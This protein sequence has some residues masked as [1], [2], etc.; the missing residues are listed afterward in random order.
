MIR[1]TSKGL[2]ATV[3]AIPLAALGV[4]ACG[5]GGSE[6]GSSPAAPPATPTG[7]GGAAAT[8]GVANNPK[9]GSIIVDSQGRTAYLFQKDQG[10][11]STCTGEC[12]SDWP[13]I[14]ATGKPVAGAGLTA[15]KIGTTARSDGDPQVTYNGHPLY[16]FEADRNPGDANGQGV[17]AFGAPWFVLN[18]TGAMIS[19]KGSN[20]SGGN[21]Y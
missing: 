4:S 20:Q 9:L 1:L 6:T 13:P 15:S 17:T 21:G 5:G 19:G 3:V 12:A 14:R 2:L 8:I 18:P 10:T 16:L 7:S 11:K